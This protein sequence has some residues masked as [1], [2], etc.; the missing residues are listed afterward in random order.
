VNQSQLTRTGQMLGT[1]AYMSPEQA[2]GEAVDAQ[3]DLWS[4]GAVLYEMLTGQRPFGGADSQAVIFAIRN[5]E[6]KPLSVLRPEVPPALEA[7]VER[8]LKKAPEMRHASAAA[9]RDDL[10]VARQ[11]SD[12]APLNAFPRGSRLRPTA[13]QLLIGA[14]AALLILLGVGASWALWSTGP[15]PITSV[16]VLSLTSPSGNVEEA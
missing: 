4:L 1:V 3:T 12:G 14:A 5:E 10:R 8:C 16:A 6:P 15:A 2:K 7:V 11:N 9:L 13:R